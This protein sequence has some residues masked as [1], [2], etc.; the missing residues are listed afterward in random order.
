MALFQILN[1]N[2][3]I[4]RTTPFPN[5]AA[6]Q[7]LFDENLENIIGVRR[8]D[9]QYPIPNG[10]IDT[11]GIDERNVP[12]VIEYKHGHDPGAIIQALFYLNWLKQNRRTFEML[13]REKIGL[14]VTVNWNSQPRVIIVAK[15]FDSKELSAVNQMIPLVELKRYKYYEGEL[16]TVEDATPVIL[17]LSPSAK[18]KATETEEETPSLESIIKSVSPPIQDLFWKLRENI[19]SLGDDVRESIGKG[20]IDYRKTTT[21]I[22]L[23]IQKKKLVAFIKMGD[24]VVYDPKGITSRVSWYGDLPPHLA[25]PAL[26]ILRS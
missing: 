12:V 25:A 8:L 19:F 10:R 11:L 5:E 2:A 17:P 24:N 14:Q 6:L 26:R 15:D 4:I 9:S 3:S 7:K 21:F 1:G 16:L 18:E 23:N 20:W 13:A 22:S